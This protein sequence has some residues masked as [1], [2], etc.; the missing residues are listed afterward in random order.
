M[1]NES[2][3]QNVT[4]Y[5]LHFRCTLRTRKLQILTRRNF[6]SSSVPFRRNRVLWKDIRTSR[7]HRGGRMDSKEEM[8]WQN[9]AWS[10]LLWMPLMDYIL[11]DSSLESSYVSHGFQT[12]GASQFPQ[13]YDIITP[14][15][16]SESHYVQPQSFTNPVTFT[17]STLRS[18]WWILIYGTIFVWSCAAPYTNFPTYLLF[19]HRCFFLFPLCARFFNVLLSI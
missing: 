17:S 11:H 16:T 14:S 8:R 2:S 7:S 5:Q 6:P 19:L 4:L 12:S 9:R 13:L 3:R 18:V 10:S 1:Y 15:L